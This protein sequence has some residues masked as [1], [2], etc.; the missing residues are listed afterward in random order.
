VAG[1]TQASRHVYS[2]DGVECLGKW[3]LEK[4]GK[5]P[6]NED[7]KEF[8]SESVSLRVP[9]LRTKRSNPAFRENSGLLRR[10]RS[11]Q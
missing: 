10:L 7:G 1:A 11:S 3:V 4:R 2:H 6:V 8:L 5:Y 9:S